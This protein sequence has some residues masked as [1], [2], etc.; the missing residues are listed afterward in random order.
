MTRILLID[1]SVLERHK[2]KAFLFGELEDVK[3]V[4]A[5]DLEDLA[6][7]DECHFQALTYS[8][9][10]LLGK[11]E[12]KRLDN[13]NWTVDSYEARVK[14]CDNIL[15][16][17]KAEEWLGLE[18]DGLTYV[19]ADNLS[20]VDGDCY[21]LTYDELWLPKD[22]ISEITICDPVHY[23]LRFGHSSQYYRGDET[24]SGDFKPARHVFLPSSYISNNDKSC[25]GVVLADS[26]NVWDFE[27]GRNL[28]Y[29]ERVRR[30][31]RWEYSP[32][33]QAV[34]Y[35]LKE[36]PFKVVFIAVSMEN[37]NKAIKAVAKASCGEEV[38]LEEIR[39]VLDGRTV[40]MMYWIDLLPTYLGCQ[41]GGEGTKSIQ[42]VKTEKE[43]GQYWPDK[44]HIVVNRGGELTQ[45]H[46]DGYLNP[47]N[48]SSR[49]TYIF[50][51]FQFEPD[52]L[53][54][55]SSYLINSNV[56]LLEIY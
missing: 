48:T 1:R 51:P 32:C 45:T 3:L 17:D 13:A 27:D 5:D 52:D 40:E 23:V 35:Y 31:P 49:L 29:E 47:F 34:H 39:P 25:V 42:L 14:M 8:S 41:Y 30:S 18:K 24:Y 28:S 20:E 4:F 19:L 11:L 53:K 55:I 9:T 26:R 22:K 43:F 56:A 46:I 16:I 33:E 2:Q 50:D 37:I 44:Y 36:I 7:C 6:R 54:A 15:V 21:L 10:V 12:V 38:I